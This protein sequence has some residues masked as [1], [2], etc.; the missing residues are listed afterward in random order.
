[1]LTSLA[2]IEVGERLRLARPDAVAELARSMAEVGLLNP[3]TVTPSL[4]LVA[5]N[6]RL[7]AARLLGWDSIAVNVVDID[8]NA[9]RL[10]EIDENLVRNEL[11]ALERAEHLAQRKSIYEAMHPEAKHGATGKGRPKSGQVGHSIASFADATAEQLN[12]SARNIRR[13]LAIVEKLPQAIRDQIRSLPIADNKQEL[14][15]LAAVGANERA[16][17]AAEIASGAK[18]VRQAQ[19]AVVARAIRAEAPP[20]PGGRYRVLVIDPPWAYEKRENDPSHRSALDYPSMSLDEIAALPVPDL[21]HDDAVLWLWTTNAYLDAAH[22]LAKGWGFEVKTVLTWAKDR[23]GLGDWLR[24][25]TEHALLAVRGRPVVELA[26]QSTLLTA[27]RRGH[28]R[29]PEEFYAL[30]ESLCPGSKLE[31]FARQSREGWATW[32]AESEKF[33]GAF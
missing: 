19:R 13:D 20:L 16:C 21:A 33:R 11:S 30:V 3:I 32:G 23:L 9:T 2:L 29:K 5:G 24:G 28:S 10:A 8:D 18:S 15:R 27:K 1:M 22:E 14:S 4:H 6:H 17:V 25:Q 31:L 7:Q 26:G 12:E